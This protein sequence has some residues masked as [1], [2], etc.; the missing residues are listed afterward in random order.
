MFAFGL[1]EKEHGADIY[2]SDMMLYPNA[3]G[4]YRANGDKY[5]IGN[6]NEAALVSTFAK[7]ADTRRIRLLRGQLQAREVRMRA[8][9]GE[10]AEL[11]GRIR[12]ARLPITD[13]D[14]T[15][16][17]PK[18]WDDML[19]TINVCKFNL[20]W[21]AIGLCT[22]ALYESIDHAA[23]RNVYGKFVT[24]FPHVKR[25]FTDAY[26]RLVAMKLFA[27]R[28]SDYMRSAGPDDR[29]YLLYNPMVKMNLE[30]RRRCP[31]SSSWCAGPWRASTSAA[32]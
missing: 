14:I 7:M 12:A 21:G 26:C 24:D 29:R 13:A 10:R 27:E 32:L 30:A 5:Y 3:D 31:I 2:S 6:G 23:N 9:R 1:S 19:N 20:G 28:A 17:G 16:K 22:H 25:L 8:E 15:E 18:A 4:T 11:R